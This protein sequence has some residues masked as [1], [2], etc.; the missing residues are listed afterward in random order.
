MKFRQNFSFSLVFAIILLSAGCLSIDDPFVPAS[1]PENRLNSVPASYPENSLNFVPASYPENCL[2]IYNTYWDNFESTVKEGELYH[3]IN[4]GFHRD[5]QF[6]VLQVL[7]EGQVLVM[8]PY[9]I[10][11]VGSKYETICEEA[12]FMVIS[13]HTYADGA[14][15]QPGEYFCG[16]P[17]TYTTVKNITKPVY[18]F[19]EKE[20]L[21]RFLEEKNQNK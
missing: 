20:T 5:L 19:I 15:L 14:T 21:R 7:G 12:I 4:K 16:K 8:R 18:T 6:T 9:K 10:G 11:R 13:D 3:Y 17:Y 1:Y 2:N